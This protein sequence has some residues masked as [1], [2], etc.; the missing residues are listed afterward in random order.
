MPEH[1]ILLKGLR[2]ISSRYGIGLLTARKLMDD[3]PCFKIGRTFYCYSDEIELF[4][5][6]KCKDGK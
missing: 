5:K 1:S 4:L 3:V 6:N 2:E